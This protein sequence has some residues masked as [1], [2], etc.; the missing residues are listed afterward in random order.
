M[1]FSILRIALVDKVTNEVFWRMDCEHDIL[2][3]IK[4][5]KL[6]YF[7]HIMRNSSK[8]RILQNIVKDKIEIR[9]GP[10]DVGFLDSPT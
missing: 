2:M 9:R 4:R 5:R 6:E 10:G 1:D 7:G 3:A 8:Y